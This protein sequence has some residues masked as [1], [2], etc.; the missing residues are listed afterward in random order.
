M[1][2]IGLGSNLGN[3]EERLLQAMRALH[4][5]RVRIVDV[6]SFWETEPIGLPDQ[7]DYL[8]AAC[9]VKTELKPRALLSACLIT[10]EKL[11]RV[12][13][14]K[15]GPRTVDL[16]ILFY[17][18][19]II[20]RRGLKIPHPSVADRRFVLEPL[21]EI[22]ADFRDPVSSRTVAELLQDCPDQGRC[23]VRF[24]RIEVR[25]WLRQQRV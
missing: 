19:K 2:F 25:R 24:P 21:S 15:W 12:R 17:G 22:A 3:R 10:E 13:I 7:P 5:L 18:K 16:D 8:N 9:R 20:D 6:S 11:G 1:I 4:Q 23:E 14:E